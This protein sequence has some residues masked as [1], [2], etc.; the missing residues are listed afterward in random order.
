MFIFGQRLYLLDKKENVLMG[1]A[2]ISICIKH[3][4][5]PEKSKLKLFRIRLNVI[6]IIANI[7]ML[8]LITVEDVANTL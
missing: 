1:G 8:R 4:K 3:T 6:T 5:E 7:Y 2:K